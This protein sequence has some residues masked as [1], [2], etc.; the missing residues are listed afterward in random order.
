LVPGSGRNDHDAAAVRSTF[1]AKPQCGIFYFE[2]EIVSKGR[3]GYISIGFCDADASM[4]KLPGKHI[5][6]LTR[7][8][9]GVLRFQLAPKKNFRT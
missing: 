6:L 3:D 5:R 7:A 9:E 8:S 2:I 1:T 4:D